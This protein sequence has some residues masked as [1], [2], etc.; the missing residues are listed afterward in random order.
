MNVFSSANQ[1]VVDD[2]NAIFNLLGYPSQVLSSSYS[3]SLL[4]LAFIPSSSNAPSTTAPNG[5]GL[6]PQTIPDFSGL[7]LSL[8]SYDPQTFGDPAT[9]F[10]GPSG[11]LLPLSTQGYNWNLSDP[12]E[13][14][15]AAANA[16]IMPQNSPF[17]K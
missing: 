1:S 12:V 2:T 4:P 14:A 5:T 15:F 8:M 3:G 7:G 9:L 16:P 17:F 10:T 6:V 13:A 11:I